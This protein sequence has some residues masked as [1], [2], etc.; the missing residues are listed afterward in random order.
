MLIPLVRFET[1]STRMQFVKFDKNKYADAN[2]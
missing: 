1:I 2:N